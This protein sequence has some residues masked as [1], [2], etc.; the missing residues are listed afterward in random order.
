MKLGCRDAVGI[1]RV[2]NGS[3]MQQWDSL[4]GFS[5]PGGTKDYTEEG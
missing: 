5:G 2:V 3:S 1:S 4:E